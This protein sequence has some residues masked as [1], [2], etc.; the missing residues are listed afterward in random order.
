M[1]F[2]PLLSKDDFEEGSV[3]IDR[4]HSDGS[5]IS[6]RGKVEVRGR[7]HFV[8]YDSEP[9]HEVSAV[10]LFDDLQVFRPDGTFDCYERVGSFERAL[11]RLINDR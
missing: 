7:L 5:S 2:I 11:N 9:E 10:F 3:A 1:K 4:D 8:D 6:I